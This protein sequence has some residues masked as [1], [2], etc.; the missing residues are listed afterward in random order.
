MYHKLHKNNNVVE[1][2]LEFCENNT[3]PNIN[4]IFSVYLHISLLRRRV[5]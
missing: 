1:L 5:K 2:N 3:I 4:F